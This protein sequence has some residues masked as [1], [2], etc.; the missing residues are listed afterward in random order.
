MTET[1]P[2]AGG[3]PT[4]WSVYR[5]RIPWYP[6]SGDRA[7]PLGRHVSHDSRNLLYRHQHVTPHGA[8]FT[9]VLHK[10]NIPILDQGDVGSCTGNGETGVLGCDPN[11]EALPAGHPALDEALALK[12]YSGAE[13]IDG[14]GPYPPN[15]NGSSGPSAAK[16]A[17]QLGLI[18]GYTHCLTL[19]DVLDALQVQAVS[20][21]INWY[22]CIPDG[23]RVL[24]SDLRWVPIEKIQVGD[25][26]I[27]FDES[28][29]MS[30]KYRRSTVTDLGAV[31][32]PVYEITTTQGTVRSSAGHLFVRCHAKAGQEWARADSIK[33]GDRL[34]YFMEPYGEDTSWEAGYLAGFFDGEGTVAGDYQLNFGQALGPT[35]DKAVRLLEAKGYN[36]TVKQ[37]RQPG[38]DGRG[39]VSRKP[40]ANVYV[41]GGYKGALRFLGEMRPG[42]LLA[43]A[44]R[45]WEGK[46][47]KS[48]TS[49]PVEV[50]SVRLVGDQKVNMIGTSTKT[51]IVEGFL[52]HNCFDSP[53]SS[54]LLTI[55]PG[56]Q[57]RGGHE[58]MLRGIDVTAQ[59][60]FGD[61]S[62]GTSWG[63]DGSFS[64]GWA[65]LERLLA[66]DGDGTVSVPLS[67]PAPTP[68]PGPAPA[69]DQYDLAFAHDPRVQRWATEA[70]PLSS[71]NR[72]AVHA[73]NTWRHA[74]G[75]S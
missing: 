47:T 42:R 26:L 6:A 11:Y 44:H 4:S 56:A 54:G 20:I 27:G 43:N 18:S 10:R 41:S 31:N 35:L 25:E 5:R 14:D 37:L 53:P 1:Q 8:E 39:I 66:E 12:I 68:V 33:P 58:P 48:R 38:V 28:I 34:A 75:I 57:V 61:N 65:T 9:S 36:Y 21:G 23:Q 24:T 62:W 46:A 29:G 71:D 72:H 7:L 55:S 49:P 22:D 52:S 17:M 67:A 51:L 19:N 45:L 64:M 50:L 3:L 74:K 69:A 30:A 16:A 63:V 2:D 13:T 40:L 32:R 73:F 15:D 60:V 59:T 70:H